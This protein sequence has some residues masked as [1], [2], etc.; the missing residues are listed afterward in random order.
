M[1]GPMN[2]TGVVERGGVSSSFHDVREGDEVALLGR[3]PMSFVREWP[4]SPT[5]AALTVNDRLKLEVGLWGVTGQTTQIPTPW[6]ILFIVRVTFANGMPRVF[7]GKPP[8][9]R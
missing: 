8:G 6:K 3:E 4:E 7:V 1:H 2:I 9:F 5:E